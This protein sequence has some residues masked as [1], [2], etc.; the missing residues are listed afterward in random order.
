MKG[1]VLDGREETH[2]NLR[3]SRRQ[4]YILPTRY[5]IFSL[6]W[7]DC[8]YE[9]RLVCEN[10]TSGVLVLCNVMGGDDRGWMRNGAE[11]TGLDVLYGGRVWK[12]F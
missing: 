6:A 2:T 1:Q 7:L 11:N 10:K 4:I 3:N 12:R 5:F 8:K 9:N